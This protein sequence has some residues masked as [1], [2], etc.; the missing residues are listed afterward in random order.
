MM[1]FRTEIRRDS[2][3]PVHMIQGAIKE[4]P[5]NA[6]RNGKCPHRGF[7]MAQV[8]PDEY[9]VKTCPMHGMRFW[10]DTGKGIP[11][12]K[13]GVEGE[14]PPNMTEEKLWLRG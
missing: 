11:Y 2:R 5:C 3:T 6:L 8:L 12:P 10:A 9:G 13:R 4:V 7:N 14:P 1:V